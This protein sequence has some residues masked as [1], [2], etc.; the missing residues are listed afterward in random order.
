MSKMLAEYRDLLS[1]KDLAKI[2]DVSKQTI[3]KE[4]QNGKFGTPIKI[5]REIKISKIYI[6]KR[7]F[8]TKQI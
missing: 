5:G 6:I 3:Y 2:F 4:M 1:V 8:S 7:Y